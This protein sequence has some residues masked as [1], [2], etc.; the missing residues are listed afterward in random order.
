MLRSNM[1]LLNYEDFTSY[2]FDF[3]EQKR[4]SKIP[5]IL[6]T[7]DNIITLFLLAEASN[8]SWLILF[9]LYNLLPNLLESKKIIFLFLNIFRLIG[10]SI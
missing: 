1:N 5:F 8:L 7:K 9:R 6:V 3:V 4:F 2:A 10:V